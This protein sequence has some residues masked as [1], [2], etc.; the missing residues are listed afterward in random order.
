MYVIRSRPQTVTAVAEKT[1]SAYVSGFGQDAIFR[2]VS[3]GWHA[4][5]TGSPASI[6]VGE[7][8]PALVVGDQVVIEIRRIDK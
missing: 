6:Y 7:E 8:R 3:D 4:S 1:H 5:L 2:T